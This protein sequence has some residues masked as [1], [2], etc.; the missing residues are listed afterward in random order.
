M[1]FKPRNVPHEL[2]SFCPFQVALYDVVGK[3]R[4]FENVFLIAAI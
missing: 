4:G 3:F 2:L 1:S